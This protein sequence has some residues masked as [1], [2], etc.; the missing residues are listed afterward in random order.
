[1][2]LI[3]QIPAYNEEATIAKTLL[4]LPKKIEGITSIET[5]VIDDG[6]SDKTAEA[7]RKAGATHL[8]QLRTHR[9]LSAAFVAGIDAALRLGADIIVNT[10]ADN[11]YVAADIVRLINPIMK[12]TAE[13]VIGDR[14]VSGS[15]H[16]SAFKRMLQR[17][18][19]WAVSKASGVSVADATSGFRAFSRE[20]AMQINVFNPFTYTLETIIQAGQRNLGVQTVT[21]RTNPPTRPSR[22]YG[23]IATYLRKSVAT[24]FR[25][26][27]LYRPLKTF[28]AIG[29]LLMVAGVAIGARFLA[30]YFQ[31]DGGGHIQSLILAS[32]FLVIGFNTWLIALLADLIAVNRR[33]SEDVLLRLKRMEMPARAASRP[34]RPQQQQQP[35]RER[36][37]R[38]Q[39]RREAPAVAAGA[40]AA[41][42]AKPETQWVW[43]LDEDKLQDDEVGDETEVPV[44]SPQRDASQARRRRRRRGGVRHAPELPGNRGKHLG[45]E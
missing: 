44:P 9:G 12:G 28:F 26:H 41:S 37:E 6:S 45:E 25:V 27:T 30:H 7:A 17:M 22:L 35:Q 34:A 23:G 1:M 15:P 14:E 36:G 19:S 20:A 10:D 31:G 11:Q 2:K 39:P 4:D 38:P 40:P 33:L 16:M 43:L 21:V 32:V 42:A 24:I 8:V 13:V 18:G 5:L 29:T 3:I